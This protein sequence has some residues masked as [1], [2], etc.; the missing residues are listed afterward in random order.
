MK[1]LGKCIIKSQNNSRFEA[2]LP[3]GLDALAEIIND[4]VT[5]GATAGRQETTDDAGDV[6]PDVE[7]LRT[8]HTDALY[9]QAE[10]ADAWE[11]HRLTVGKPMFQDVL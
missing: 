1:F 8:V 10:T 4:M 9:T 7:C 3:N 6:M 5:L 2:F 11:H